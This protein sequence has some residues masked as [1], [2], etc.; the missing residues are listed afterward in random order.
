M[1]IGILLGVLL[2][3]LIHFFRTSG[4][5]I[6]E[7]NSNFSFSE[8]EEK[9]IKAVEQGAW[10]MPAVHNLQEI[11]AKNG[12]KVLPVKVFEICK[13]ELANSILS[14]SDERKMSAMMP[15]RVSLYQKDDGS[16]CFSRINA[17]M[18][19]GMLTGH[20]KEVMTKAANEMEEIINSI[21]K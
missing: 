14:R 3:L 12:Y 1:T 15:C 13:P 2:M 20:I 6:K 16:I 19:S 10:K 9:L 8:S 7:T 11:M 18:M 21:N 17:K 4:E 5:M